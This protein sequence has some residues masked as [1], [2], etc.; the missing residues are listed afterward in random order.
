MVLRPLRKEQD[1][2][3]N[4]VS[5]TGTVIIG[6]LERVPAYATIEEGSLCRNA[7]GKVVFEHAGDTKPYWD[8]QITVMRDNNGRR[9]VV[10]VDDNGAEWLES[11][12]VEAKE[13]A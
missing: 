7:E 3:S 2:A 11:A 10:F 9:E 5:P 4:L 1:M 8:D 12:L 6:T 13:V